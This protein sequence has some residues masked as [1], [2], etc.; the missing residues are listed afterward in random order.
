MNLPSLKEYHQKLMNMCYNEFKKEVKSHKNFEPNS[1]TLLPTVYRCIRK[2]EEVC[3]VEYPSGEI[4][5]C[6]IRRPYV[7]QK[8]F[9]KV[10][11][12]CRSHQE[13]GISY[14]YFFAT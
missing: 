12:L 10:N 3:Q 1:K 6:I 7:R 5:D 13:A 4:V 9:I 8:V 2:S 11:L 14:M